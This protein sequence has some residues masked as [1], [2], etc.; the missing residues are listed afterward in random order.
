[1]GQRERFTP[2]CYLEERLTLTSRQRLTE[3]DIEEPERKSTK[4]CNNNLN[5]RKKNTEKCNNNLNRRKNTNK[6]NSNLNSRINNHKCNNNLNRGKNTNKCNN[7]NRKR[8]A[9]RGLKKS[10]KYNSFRR[11]KATNKFNII[12]RKEPAHSN[13]TRRRCSYFKHSETR[14][15]EFKPK[16]AECNRLAVH[17]FN[18]SATLSSVSKLKC[19]GMI[20]A[21]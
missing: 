4:K 6:C 10:N 18:H 20:R 12:R 5:L 16:H 7:F 9:S 13:G 3:C 11:R 21:E 17:R 15:M 8:T 1:M 19:G 14:S 2:V